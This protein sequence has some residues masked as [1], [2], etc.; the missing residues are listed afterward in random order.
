MT[1]M[2]RPSEYRP[3]FC[4]QVIEYGS[5][6]KSVAWMA[7]EL[8]VSRECIYEWARVHPEFSDAITQAKLKSQRWWEDMGQ[9]NMLLPPGQGTMNASIWSRSMAARFPEDWREKQETTLKG[10]VTIQASPIDERL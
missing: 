1:I 8:G 6:G 2:G 9:D 7:A 3:E 10:G 5:R 4:E